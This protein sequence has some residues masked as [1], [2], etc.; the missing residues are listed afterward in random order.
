MTSSAP[1]VF[2]L[3]ILDGFV[4]TDKVAAVNVHTAFDVGSAISFNDALNIL[5]SEKKDREDTKDNN[6]RDDAQD[7]E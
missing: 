6:H 7:N 2:G 5:R 3:I 1:V 4:T